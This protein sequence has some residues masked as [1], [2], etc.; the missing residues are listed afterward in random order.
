LALE[1]KTL[2]QRNAIQYR[3]SLLHVENFISLLN[4]NPAA[5]ALANNIPE[6]ALLL[7]TDSSVS[8]ALSFL[9]YSNQL[10]VI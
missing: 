2:V 9:I 6:V 3:I 5:F 1:L 4:D 10:R 7:S 8:S